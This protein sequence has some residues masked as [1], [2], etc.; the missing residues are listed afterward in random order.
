MANSLTVSGRISSTIVGDE[1]AAGRAAEVKALEESMRIVVITRIRPGLLSW[2]SIELCAS[3][4]LPKLLRFETLLN[5]FLGLSRS[6]KV[7]ASEMLKESSLLTMELL[8]AQGSTRKL[9]SVR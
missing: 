4:A 7:S 8:N 3:I 2:Q 6:L 9:K 5:F 1:Q